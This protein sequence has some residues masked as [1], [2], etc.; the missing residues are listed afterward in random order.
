MRDEIH[1]GAVWIFWPGGVDSGLEGKG[2]SLEPVAA[3]RRIAH[4]IDVLD[5]E[6]SKHGLAVCERILLAW[7]QVR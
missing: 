6:I 5:A 7:K 4:C 2:T 1:V 3:E